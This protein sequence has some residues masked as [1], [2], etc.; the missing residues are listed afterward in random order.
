MAKQIEAS[1]FSQSVLEVAPAL[2]GKVL[3]RQ[4]LDGS[5]LRSLVVE[6]EAYNGEADSACHASKGKTERTKVMYHSGGTI[7]IYLIYGMYHMLNIVTGAKEQPEAV[8]IR[9]IQPLSLPDNLKKSEIVSNG[10]GKLCRYLNIERSLNGLGLQKENRLWLEYFETQKEI[11]VISSTRIG[12]GYAN[13]ADQQK[14]WRFLMKDN[15]FVSKP[16]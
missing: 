10:P 1:F 7:Y 2:I 3:C 6:T 5:I 13:E 9:A 14:P 12:I 4:L 16:A 8:L 11:E 15:R